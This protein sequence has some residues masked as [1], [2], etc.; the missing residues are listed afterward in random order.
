MTKKFLNLETFKASNI[1]KNLSFNHTLSE[2]FP[3]I[4][5]DTFCGNESFHLQNN[6]FFNEEDFHF[7]EN[8]FKNDFLV[9]KTSIV[10]DDLAT[11]LSNDETSS[12]SSSQLFTSPALSPN[13]P[14]LYSPIP[15]N[16]S[17]QLVVPATNIQKIFNNNIFSQQQT[18]P[19]NSFLISLPQQILMQSS[20][21]QVSVCIFTIHFIIIF[22]FKHTSSSFLT[23][24]LN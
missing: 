3:L 21:I 6:I 1:N 19:Q 11:V 9:E 24:D 22:N 17:Q 16:L 4:D 20:P 5:S 7:D 10:Q 13:L 15:Q 12:E 23:P 2:L 18:A 8:N 14:N